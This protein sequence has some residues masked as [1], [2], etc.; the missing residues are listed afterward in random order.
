VDIF[1]YAKQME[2]DGE[3]YYRELAAQ[4]PVSGLKNILGLLADAE[5]DH[6]HTLVQMQRQED[7]AY[8]EG[9]LRL[10]SKNIFAQMIDQ[11]AKA[12]FTAS[13]IDHYRKAQDLE[14]KSRDF[15][16]EKADEAPSPK[17]QEILRQIAEE[18]RLHYQLLDSMIEFMSRPLPGNWLENAE[19]H[20]RDEY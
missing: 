3:K 15:Y 11:G 7:V 1:E 8:D 6:Y 2:K 12:D 20:H 4:C 18:E 5:V 16:L 14:K 9:T 17:V 13:E 19:W 10:D